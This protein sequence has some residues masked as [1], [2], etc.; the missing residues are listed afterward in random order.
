MDE[1][2][3]EE[4]SWQPEITGVGGRRW[5][6]I[7]AIVV[8]LI[9]A[10][11]MGAGFAYSN[12]S[13]QAWRESSTQAASDLASTRQDLTSVTQERD[14]LRGVRDEL[15]RTQS[16]LAD[17]T[18]KFNAVSDRI[19]SLSNEKAQIGDQAAL[20]TEFL[21]MSHQ[22]TQEMD[23]CISALQ[24]LEGYLVNYRSYDSV[25]L[26]NYTQGINKGCNQA[27]ADSDALSKKLG[28]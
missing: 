2:S 15:T 11:G 13:A 23:Q 7:L 22:V 24:T 6:F 18:S 19:R 25:S 17:M 20:M 10:A 12:S 21:A 26:G 9:V 28:G 14:Q 27:R 4:S 3:G 1:D 8:L 16:S 5:P